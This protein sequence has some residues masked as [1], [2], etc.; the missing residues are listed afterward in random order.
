V[1]ATPRGPS[2]TATVAATVLVAVS[3]TDTLSL[4]KFVT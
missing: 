2:P 3:I 1:T 4:L